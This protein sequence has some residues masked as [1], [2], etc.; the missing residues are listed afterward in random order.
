MIQPRL[1][2]QSCAVLRRSS[3]SSQADNS[4]S[5][6]ARTVDQILKLCKM[7]VVH[8]IDLKGVSGSLPGNRT[9]I[10]EIIAAKKRINNFNFLL[11]PSADRFTRAGQMHGLSMLWD[12]AKA[13]ITVY[14]VKE[15][16]FSDDERARSYLG[17]LFDSARQT[18]YA[19]GSASTE[20]MT[21]AI[22]DGKHPYTL[23]PPFGLDRLYL[24]D[25]KRMH[26]IRNL[27][28]GK[29]QMWTPETNRAK[30]TL[31]REFARNPQKGTPNH[32][33]KQKNESVV[34]IPGD[35]RAVKVVQLFMELKWVRR[36]GVRAATRH[37]N[38]LALTKKDYMSGGGNLWSIGTVSRVVYNPVY[39]GRG[40]RLMTST[41]VYVVANKSGKPSASSVTIEELA[42]KN[43]PTRKF[44][45]REQWIVQLQPH[46]KG[47]LPPA[48]HDAASRGIEER[49]HLRARGLKLRPHTNRYKGGGRLL[50][51]ILRSKQ[52]DS[53]MVGYAGNDPQYEYYQ[54]RYH[55]DHPVSGSVMSKKIP[56]HVLHPPV[57]EC[58]KDALTHRPGLSSAMAK[59]VKAVRNEQSPEDS[60]KAERELMALRAQQ[61]RLNRKI[62]G[63]SKR[64]KHVDAELD[65]L[66]AK[67]V[68]LQESQRLRP[69]LAVK[70]VMS[71][72]RLA[73]L[74]IELGGEIEQ[75]DISIKKALLK[76]LVKRMVVDLET[77]E[78]EL[79][80]ALPENM[81][82][83]LGATNKGILV[84]RL[85][86]EG[87]HK[88][89]PVFGPKL[90][91][92]MLTYR[93]NTRDY[94]WNRPKKAS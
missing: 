1:H 61:V 90:A 75:M 71:A 14:F 46:L 47:F 56:G 65:L 83:V 22:L 3:Q 9:D 68:R 92:Y 8:E 49:L 29:Q 66:D 35:P 70:S 87:C 10:Q 79:D 39:I 64:D 88:N 89:T 84:A 78:V 28:S 41:G 63:I 19:I 42:T 58:L 55:D 34:L 16:L 80:F 62:T 23:R 74:F 93:W 11:L 30:R 82:E 6:Q 32:Y 77:R 72:E 4:N 27:P 53:R 38:D 59:A 43:K 76:C 44:R 24:V 94:V 33:R 67:I 91:S 5:N 54:C 40:V 51:D 85:C 21:Y 81:Y 26:I 45:S 15:D 37:V 7:T 2:K 25:N 86:S 60:V 52:G 13:G 18:A 31:I 36:L 73:Q 20:G 12:L 50:T 57:L 48:I 17:F 69:K